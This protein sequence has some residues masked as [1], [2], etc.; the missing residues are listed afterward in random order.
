M[1]RLTSRS[2]REFLKA[3]GLAT[4][5]L[6]IGVSL[7]VVGRL[8]AASAEAAP[9][10]DLTLTAF[11]KIGTD[12]RVTLVVPKSEMG[13]G[14]YTGLAQAIADELEIDWNTLAVESAPVAEVYNGPFAPMQYTGG[15]SSIASSFAAM[16]K[17]GAQARLMLVAAGAEAFGVPVNE[18]HAEHG[19]IVH[20]RSGKRATYGALATQ[21]AKQPPPADVPLKDPKQWRY[22]GKSM[23]RVDTR[24]KTTGQA[25]FGLDVRLPGLHY[26]VVARPPTFGGKVASV[27]RSAAKAVPGVVAIKEV[28]S[29]VAVI[30]KN[31][32]AAMQGR[33]AL[34]VEWRDGPGAGFSSSRLAAEYAEQAQKPGIV[35]LNQGDAAHA[36]GTRQLTADYV[37]PYLAHAPMEPLNCAVAFRPD[38]C[39]VYTGTQFQTFDRAAAASVAGLPPE[40]VRIHTTYLGG[41]FGRRA[42]PA[43]DFVREAVAVAKDFGAPV[44]TVWSREDDIHGGYYR[45]QAHNRLT[46]TLGSD[47]KPVAWTHTQ[48]VQSLAKGTVLEKMVVDPKTGLER[49]QHEGASEVPYQIPNLQVSVHDGKAPVP[50]LWWRSVGHSN[51]AFAVE[52]FIDECAHAA[53]AD[54]VAYRLSLLSGQPRHSAALKLAAE[55]AQ[56]GRKLPAGRARGVAVHASFNSVVAQIAE[57]SLV[58]GQPRVHRVVAAVHCGTAVNPSLITSQIESAICFGLS[59]ALYG[60]ITLENGRVQ[61]SN[62]NDYPPLRMAEMPAVEVHIVPSEDYPTG[63]GEPGLPPIA[64]AVANAL[65]ALTGVRARRLPL[66]HASFTQPR[67][68]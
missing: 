51:T 45:P 31:T 68:T 26:A 13:Q 6:V 7:P 24:A 43:G 25:E 52:S 40:K 41:G 17:A 3:S 47:G 23:P 10:A 38:G 1:A 67:P 5:G 11:V 46:A 28:P 37:T 4:G 54:P 64:P 33:K 65:Y 57:V 12:N 29:G 55:K 22:I 49:V 56:W 2:R 50:V 15:S 21:A 58:D 36:S 63:I 66:A 18:L 61:Q 27:D 32:W 53:G 35:V 16:R 19:Q 34:K 48:A 44:L 59:A 42:N 9:A 30:A 60:E 8:G 62:F 14:V 20:A 39:D